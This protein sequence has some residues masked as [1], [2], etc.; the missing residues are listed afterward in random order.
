M[1]NEGVRFLLDALRGI[2]SHVSLLEPGGCQESWHFLACGCL[3]Q[4]L[5]YLPYLHVAF[6][7]C[8]STCPLLQGL[9]LLGLIAP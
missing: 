3:R 9:E 6:S 8:M 5:P 7:V 4:T 1:K 2:L